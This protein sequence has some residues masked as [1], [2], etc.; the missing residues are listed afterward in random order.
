MFGLVLQSGIVRSGAKFSLFLYFVITFLYRND[1]FLL[2]PYFH[3]V[4]PHALH[5]TAFGKIWC[6]L[7]SSWNCEWSHPCATSPLPNHCAEYIIS[8]THMEM[9]EILLDWFHTEL[10]ELQL[11]KSL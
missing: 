2:N 8:E 9:E 10:Q 1:I 6:R 4:E 7:L 11:M 5:R 3:F